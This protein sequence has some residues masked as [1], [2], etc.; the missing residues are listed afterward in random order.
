MATEDNVDLWILFNNAY[1]RALS[2]PIKKCTRFSVNP[3]K[4]LRFLGYVIYGQQGHI[5]LEAG[6]LEVDDYESEVNPGSYYF[7]SERE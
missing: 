6:G 1:M 7:I 4:W 3:L 5:S 2:I